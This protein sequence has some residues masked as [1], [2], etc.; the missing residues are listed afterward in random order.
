MRPS[1]A[2]NQISLGFQSIPAYSPLNCTRLLRLRFNSVISFDPT[3]WFAT[4]PWDN[5]ESGRNS[6]EDSEPI[7]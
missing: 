3:S 5:L 1:R 7:R 2:A 6:F 4:K